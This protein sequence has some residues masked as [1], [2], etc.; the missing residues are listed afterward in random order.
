LATRTWKEVAW[1]GFEPSR[2]LLQRQVGYRLP[3]QARRVGEGGFEPPTA[4]FQTAHA[5]QAALLAEEV[6]ALATRTA[7]ASPHKRNEAS[8]KSKYDD[9]SSRTSHNAHTRTAVGQMD[10]HLL[11][12]G[13]GSV[14]RTHHVLLM[15]QLLMPLSYPVM[16][17]RPR[18]VEPRASGIAD[19]C[20]VLLS[21][22]RMRKPRQGSNLLPP[23]SKPG[24][25]SR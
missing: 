25:L 24:A 20:S 7:R 11:S 8:S 16:W 22:G 2:G 3:H 1:D 13:D 10:N 21:Y 5:D 19:R 9:G 15:R 17:V 6:V 12:V 23:G 4:R 18:G 14:S